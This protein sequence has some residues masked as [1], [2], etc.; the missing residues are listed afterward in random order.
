MLTRE[1]GTTEFRAHGAQSELIAKSKEALTPPKSARDQH[2]LH[3][4]QQRPLIQDPICARSRA[5]VMSQLLLADL[6]SLSSES[7]R[8][9]PE[10]RAAAEAA[11]TALR[12]DFDATL[13]RCRQY[14]Q[15]SSQDVYSTSRKPDTSNDSAAAL[16]EQNLILKPIVLACNAKTHVKV[17][18]LGVALLQRVVTMKVVPDVSV[19]TS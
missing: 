3:S 1:I 8:R 6:T 2:N 13:Q 17:V 19:R 14:Q 4:Q 10:V 15:T 5:G 16:L 18:G 9:C 12:S 11:L 7:K